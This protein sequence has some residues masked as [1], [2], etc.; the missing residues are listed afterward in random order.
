MPAFYRTAICMLG[1]IDYRVLGP[2]GEST[3]RTY[4]HAGTTPRSLD[5]NDLYLAAKGGS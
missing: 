4:P 2:E 1:V 3:G 5:K